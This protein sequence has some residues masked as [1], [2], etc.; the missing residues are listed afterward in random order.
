MRHR[1]SITLFHHCA[2][3][4]RTKPPSREG[5]TL[6]AWY[7]LTDASAAK[8][9]EMRPALVRGLPKIP[10]TAHAAAAALAALEPSPEPRGR[11]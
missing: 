6:S 11:P 3:L 2:Y 5:P 1:L 9:A 10:L 8:P 4:I 7:P